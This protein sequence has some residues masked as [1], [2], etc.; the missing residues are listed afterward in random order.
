MRNQHWENIH[1]LFDEFIHTFIINKNSFLTEE[2]TI[3]S[4]DIVNK[5]QER[6]IE[7]YNDEKDLKFQ[8][9]LASQFDG[10]SHSEK[11]VFAHAEW[12]WSYSVNDLQISTK[13]NYTKTIT[14]LDDSQIKVEPF[15]NG[16]GS[17]GQFHKTNKYWEIAFNIELIKTLLEK[18][19]EGA[20]LE[21]LKK[22]TEAICLYLKYYQETEDYPVD[23][24]FRE[25]FQ[26][27][28]LTMYNILTYCAFPDSYER[29]ASNGHKNRIYNTFNSLLTQEELESNFK[30]EAILLIRQRLNKWRKPNFDFYEYD[31]MKLW[32]Y[33]AS[34]IPYD[35]L[36]ALLYK[37][38]IVLYGPPGTSKTHSANTIANALIKESYLKNGGDLNVF[39]SDATTIVEVRIHRLQL[40]ANYT[41]EDFVAGMQLEGD[42]TK[43]KKGKL[44]EYCAF[45]KADKDKLPHVLI[46]DE[47]NRVD[48]SRVFGEVFSA[49][50]NRNTDITTAVGDFKLNI[51]SNLYIIGTMNEIDFSLEQI[52]FALRRRFLW[53]PYGYNSEILKDIVYYKNQDQRAGL[54]ERDVER[55]INAASALNT[56]I[57]ASDELGKQ[58]EIGHTFFAEVVDIYSSF[59][60][61]KNKTNRIQNKLFRAEGPAKILW[62]ISIKPILEAYL[63][64]VEEDEKKNLI[65]G[66]KDTFF[67]ASIEK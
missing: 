41:Y 8:E 15:V 55:L 51:P 45:A 61:I 50:E 26:D 67:R 63:G 7:N 20:G 9:K 47:I 24:K 35:E 38:A 32:N 56:A 10:A 34:D 49:M 2:K 40:H 6:F 54:S 52:D 53:F 46:L 58:F 43:P 14:G 60:A 23:N 30:D 25:R 13:K 66:L 12:L 27:K 17:A 28:A 22:W 5:I 44:F 1:V 4:I 37:K 29:I 19:A 48:L 57:A 31:L 39:F 64:N 33:S 21:E 16:F 42:E 62:D 65:K 11:L 59:K 36:Q 3:L 18:E